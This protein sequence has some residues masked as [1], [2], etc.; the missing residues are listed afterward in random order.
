MIPKMK[1][2]LQWQEIPEIWQ[3]LEKVWVEQDNY[4]V[5]AQILLG[6]DQARYL[7]HEARYENGDLFQ[8]EQAQLMQSAI[9]GNY[10]IFG[11]CEQHSKRLDK[12]NSWI[13]TTQIQ[14]SR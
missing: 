2:S 14:E 8:M 5:S 13:R 9:T 7:P 11:S 10:I 6:A 1:L 3:E 4:G 12:N